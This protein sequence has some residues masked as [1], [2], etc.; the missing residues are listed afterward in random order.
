MTGEEGFRSREFDE[1]DGG[2]CFPREC[3]VF[4]FRKMTIRK[5]Q[6]AL[7][8][9]LFH[10]LEGGCPGQLG[11]LVLGGNR[12]ASSRSYHALVVCAGG[13]QCASCR[14]GHNVV[15][16]AADTDT[17]CYS[18]LILDTDGFYELDLAL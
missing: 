10:I 6:Y 14:V 13:V 4:R 2:E 3:R 11:M 18:R 5:I 9:D 12:F 16:F 1:E 17:D 7:D 15:I 8:G